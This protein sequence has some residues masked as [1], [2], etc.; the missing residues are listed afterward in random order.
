MSVSFDLSRV[1]A[2]A[3]LKPIPEKKER[4]REVLANLVAKVEQNEPDTLL[5]QFWYIEDTGEFLFIE[6]YKTQETLTAHMSTPY[7]KEVEEIS[8]QE[9]IL[10]RPMDVKLLNNRVAGFTR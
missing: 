6:S 2:I 3:I 10:E 5:Y 1:N 4:A 9:G 8:V 7:F